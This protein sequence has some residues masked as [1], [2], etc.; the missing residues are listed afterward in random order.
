MTPLDPF[1]MSLRRTFAVTLKP[2]PHN[3]L[4]S[5]DGARSESRVELLS[6]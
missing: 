3:E 1:A 6:Q 5:R 4:F 2:M